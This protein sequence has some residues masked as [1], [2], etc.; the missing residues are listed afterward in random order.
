MNPHHRSVT[1][2]FDGE[3]NYAHQ[4]LEN[5]RVMLSIQG[6]DL[7]CKKAKQFSTTDK[8]GKFNLKPEKETTSYIPFLNYSMDEWVI[9]ANYNN[10]IYTLYT[11]NRYAT[12]SVTGSIYL[13]CDLSTKINKKHC[14]ISQ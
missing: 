8:Q 2:Y 11:N 10:Q 12:G 9:C 3:L 7:S 5:I 4:P 13:S 6:D 1:P 14:V